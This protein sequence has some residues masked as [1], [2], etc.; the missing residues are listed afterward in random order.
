MSRLALAAAF[1]FSLAACSDSRCSEANCKTLVNQCRLELAGNPNLGVCAAAFGSVPAGY[2]VFQFCPAS[3]NQDGAGELV[4]C[5]ISH[6]E[7]G[8][9]T[10]GGQIAAINACEKSSNGTFDAAC[11][12]TCDATRKTCESSCGSKPD[13]D[14]CMHCASDC[15]LKWAKCN[16]GCTTH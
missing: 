14:A 5:L 12:K 10:D 9:T 11:G 1:A 7:C 15:G 13:F 8:G 6:P 2:D 16:D 3:C 4:H